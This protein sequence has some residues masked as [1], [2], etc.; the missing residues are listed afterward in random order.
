MSCIRSLELAHLRIRNL[1]DVFNPG[2]PFLALK[3]LVLDNNSITSLA[4]LAGLQTL[5]TLRISNNRL[6]DA[7]PN[8]LSFAAPRSSSQSITA[9]GDMQDS[10]LPSL[11]VL[12]IAGNGLTSLLPLKLQCVPHLRSLFAQDNELQQLDGLSGLQ[13]LQELVA[14]R[15]K[16]R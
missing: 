2:S 3:E 11:Q 16:I 5:T 8:C 6:G 14:D 7:E 9:E 4:S 13:Q 1:G 15:N 10:L 12:D